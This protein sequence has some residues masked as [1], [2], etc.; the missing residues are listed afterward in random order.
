MRLPKRQR[1]I[2]LG[3]A[4]LLLAGAA[5]LVLTALDDKVAFFVSP[6]DVAAHK[7]DPDRRF[8]L[9]GLVEAG[10]VVHQPDGA[11]RFAVGDGK[12]VVTVVYQGL[13]P[14]LFREGQ[15]I[16]AQGRLRPDGTFEAAEVLAKHDETYMPKEV[17]DALKADGKWREGEGS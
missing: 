1:L 11:V 16:V 3:V 12:N 5:V 8:R 2:L 17:V 13:L 7:V 6:S 4:V 9:G 14:D 10:S 15:G